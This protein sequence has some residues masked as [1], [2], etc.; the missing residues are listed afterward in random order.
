[1]LNESMCFLFLQKKSL[2]KTIHIV[3][4]IP[5]LMSPKGIDIFL[6]WKEIQEIV[7]NYSWT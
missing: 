4:G 5:S 2:N 6:T 1:M 7:Q 3:L